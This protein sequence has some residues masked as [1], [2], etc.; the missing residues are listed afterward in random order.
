MAALAVTA[1]FG[2]TFDPV[3][4]LSAYRALGATAAQFYR[5]EQKPPTVA[6][7]LSAA[8][9]AGVKFDSIHGVFGTHIDPSNPN[10]DHRAQ[11]LN[12]YEEE[13]KLARDLGGPM[14]VVHPSAFNPGMRMMSLEEAETASIVRW[15]YLDDFLRRLGDL[16]QRL[17]VTY[18]IE[19]QPPNCP[20]GHD[21]ARLAQAVERIGSPSIRMCLDTGHAHFSAKVADAVTACAGVIA[22]FHIH[23]ND[24]RTDDHRMP[25]DGTIDWKGF[26]AALRATKSGATR[27]LEVFYDEDRVEELGRNGLG[28]RLREACALEVG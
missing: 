5:N 4:F 10:A 28:M 12:I 20:L 19:N 6:E 25:G 2:F 23:D 26:A 21:A 1:P 22:Y 27:M 11:C 18:L 14:V 13:G 3:R 8:A 24:S 16:G 7:A 9:A 15:G 17:G